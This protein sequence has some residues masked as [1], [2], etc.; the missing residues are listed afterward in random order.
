MR[1]YAELM[2]WEAL[3]RALSG[4]PGMP[5]VEARRGRRRLLRWDEV[6][7]VKT[8]WREPHPTRQPKLWRACRLL[9]RELAAGERPAVE[10]YA[11]A[12]E[13]GV[14]KR[15][16]DSAKKLLG[17]EDTRHEFG[18]RVFWRPPSATEIVWVE[19]APFLAY[20]RAR[21]RASRAAERAR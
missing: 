21:L 3:E 12:R 10:L 19:A 2:G 14:S 11:L 1:A 9:R 13:A 18:G 7:G 4:P 20:E 8:G 15:T 17:V 5:H 6:V 16:F